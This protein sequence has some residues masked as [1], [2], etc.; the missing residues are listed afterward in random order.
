[1]S[2][3]IFEKQP[4]ATEAAMTLVPT[5]YGRSK[6]PQEL[7][8]SVPIQHTRLICRD[9]VPGFWR[10]WLMC[11]ANC[12]DVIRESLCSLPFTVC[13]MTYS[14]YSHDSSTCTLVFHLPSSIIAKKTP[15]VGS[16]WFSQP[17]PSYIMLYIIIYLSTS[18]ARPLDVDEGILPASSFQELQGFLKFYP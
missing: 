4:P 1:M 17:F 12:L 2:T 16:T 15:P 7:D 14:S 3:A 10:D 6:A 18:M 13:W 11:H 8:R 9:H 5:N